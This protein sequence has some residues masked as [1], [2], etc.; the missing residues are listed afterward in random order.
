MQVVPR[1]AGFS[2]AAYRQ[3]VYPFS[4][5]RESRKHQK[6]TTIKTSVYGVPVHVDVGYQIAA[7]A[8]LRTYGKLEGEGPGLQ[9]NNW[10]TVGTEFKNNKWHTIR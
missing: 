9:T 6:L 10:L 3:A 8:G 4:N 2:I 7:L 1:S 5:D